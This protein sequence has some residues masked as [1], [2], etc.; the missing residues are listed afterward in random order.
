MLSAEDYPTKFYSFV[1]QEIKKLFPLSKDRQEALTLYAIQL[2]GDKYPSMS[3]TALASKGEF[4]IKKIRQALK[5]LQF[6]LEILDKEQTDLYETFDKRKNVY[7]GTDDMTVSKVGKKIALTQSLFDHTSKSFISGWLIFDMAI[8][9]DNKIYTTSY[10]IKPPQIKKRYLKKKNTSEEQIKDSISSKLIKKM[11]KKVI[12]QLRKAGFS[13]RHII[14]LADRWYPSEAFFSFLRKIGVNFVIALKKNSQVILPDKA[15]YLRS[16]TKRRG[17]KPKHFRREL[18]LEEYFT[19]YGKSHWVTFPGHSEL[20][21][22]KSAVLNLSFIKQ[23]KVFAI[24]FP[25]QT[26]WRYF[27]APRHYS[28]VLQMY[29]HYSQRWPVETVH[30]VLKDILGLD[31]GKMRSEPYVEGHIFLVYLVHF[32]FLKFQR[33]LEATFGITLTP[34]QLHDHVRAT[35]PLVPDPLYEQ[36]QPTLQ[37]LVI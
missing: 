18:P 5:D 11:L 31:K 20:S 36:F 25:G 19:K 10:M 1:K 21:E 2:I 26:T 34:R 22:T 17:A 28:S 8:K 6:C 37:E 4:D 16:L 13:K 14:V 24:I 7:L 29:T 3:R 35:A 33:Y 9:H 30:Q 23:V 12:L 32:Y 15:K 27:V